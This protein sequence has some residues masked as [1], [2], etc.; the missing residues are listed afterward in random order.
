MCMLLWS[1]K[2]IPLK[3]QLARQNT[4]ITKTDQRI[5]KVQK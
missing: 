4:T 5:M 3:I 1:N 2:N